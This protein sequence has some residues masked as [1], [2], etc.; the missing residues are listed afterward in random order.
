[1]YIKDWFRVFPRD[2]ILIVSLEDYAKRTRKIL[3][4][5]YKFLDMSKINNML[6]INSKSDRIIYHILVFNLKKEKKKKKSFDFN[7]CWIRVRIDS[8]H[9]LVCRKRRQWG[10][11]SDETVKTEAPRH[12]M[13]GTTKKTLDSFGYL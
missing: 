13:C 6:C 3:N 4:G 11:P 9:H 7:I 5:V 2:Q 1:V 12:S 10:D 8:P